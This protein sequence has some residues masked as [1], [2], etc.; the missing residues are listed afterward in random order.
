MFTTKSYY[1]AGHAEIH[2][3]GEMTS[4]MQQALK[5]HLAELRTYQA[6]T[7]YDVIQ[8]FEGLPTTEWRL[9]SLTDEARASTSLRFSMGRSHPTSE[10]YG[11][12]RSRC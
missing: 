12:S 8:P 3:Q 5:S 11:I 9:G 7:G 6:K 10:E 1:T 2:A 4:A